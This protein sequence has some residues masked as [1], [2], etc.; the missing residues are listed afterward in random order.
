MERVVYRSP[1]AKSIRL[2]TAPSFGTFRFVPLPQ[3]TVI[4]VVLFVKQGDR[5]M[6][7]QLRIRVGPDMETVDWLLDNNTIT[8]RLVDPLRKSSRV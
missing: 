7:N 4:D 2:V 6:V 3:H 5:N 8:G 1:N